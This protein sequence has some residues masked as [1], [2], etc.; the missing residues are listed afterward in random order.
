MSHVRLSEIW[1]YPIKSLGG[2]PLEKATVLEKGL[3]YDR[4]WM[5]VDENGLF[6]T[7]RVLPKMA[8]FKLK[9]DN[10]LAGKAGGK[11]KIH[12]S[13]EWIELPESAS[14]ELK[15][16][17]IWDDRVWVQEVD[18]QISNWFS[19]RLNVKCKLVS[20]PENNNRL[21]DERYRV[22][23]ENVSLADAYPFLIIGQKTLEMLNAKLTNPVPMNRFRPNFVFTGG[24]PHEEDT[25]R[26]FSIGQNRFIGVKPC[27]RCVLT[28]VDQETGKKEDEPL[29]TLATYRKQEN[30][31]NFGQNLVA[32]D[33]LEV[34]VGDVI[35]IQ[36]RVA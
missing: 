28:T 2:V 11:F 15:E 26:D 20:F 30:K 6:M 36:T 34:H 10:L 31:I 24:E 25:W 12:F 18:T 16:A 27:G 1:I 14:G 7:Q 22:N 5:L 13:T 4:R 17:K 21:V 35:T 19:D 29:R 32:V 9:M 33:H 3:Q 23:H 8:L